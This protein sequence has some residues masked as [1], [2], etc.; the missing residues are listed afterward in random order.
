MPIEKFI[1][2]RFNE[3]YEN[4]KYYQKEESE[5]AELEGIFLKSIYNALNESLNNERPGGLFGKPLPWAHSSKHLKNNK[6]K[7]TVRE[8]RSLIEANAGNSEN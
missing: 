3:T 8:R 4:I 6:N 5:D 7:N 2:D 1:F